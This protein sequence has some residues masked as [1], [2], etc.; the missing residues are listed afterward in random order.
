M[1]QIMRVWAISI[2]SKHVLS[3]QYT[4]GSNAIVNALSR[5]FL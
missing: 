2:G 3:T 1:N 5:N 4:P